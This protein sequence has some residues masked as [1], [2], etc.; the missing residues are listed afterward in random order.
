MEIISGIKG[1]QTGGGCATIVLASAAALTGHF[2]HGHAILLRLKIVPVAAAAAIYKPDALFQVDVEVPARKHGAARTGDGLLGADSCEETGDNEQG[3]GG[4][5]GKPS[6]DHHS[7]HIHRDPRI[8]T[9]TAFTAIQSNR[10]HPSNNR[11]HPIATHCDPHN[12]S[13]KS[14]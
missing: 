13:P 14:P 7:R 8:I 5:W 12:Q 6:Q 3:D 1:R 9:I 2:T 11:N 4:T 10:L